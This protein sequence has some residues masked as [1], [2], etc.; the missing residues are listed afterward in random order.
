LKTGE[1]LKAL[2]V[3]TLVLSEPGEEAKALKKRKLLVLERYYRKNCES[4]RVLGNTEKFL[5]KI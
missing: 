4:Y 3:Q 5:K 1:Y 2:P